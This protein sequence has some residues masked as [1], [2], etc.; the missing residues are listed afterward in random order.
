MDKLRLCDMFAGIGGIR[1]GFELA[2]KDIFTT[3]YAVDFNS[4][5]KKTYDLNFNETKLTIKDIAELKIDEI[6]DFD[7]VSAGS[8]CQ[9]YSVAGNRKGLEDNRGKIV[10]NLLKIIK[11]KN[12]KLYFW[13]MSKIFE[14]FIMASHIN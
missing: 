6:P 3:V 2:N 12:R 10:Y 8:P 11:K 14:Q 4:M 13:K 7:I 1:L 9:P 5:C